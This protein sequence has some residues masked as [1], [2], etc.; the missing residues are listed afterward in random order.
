MAHPLQ[1]SNAEARCVEFLLISLTFVASVGVALVA[2]YAALSILL[3]LMQRA[4]T[5]A[6][7]AA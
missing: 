7:R 6:V 3:G 5:R 2:A 1:F 4:V